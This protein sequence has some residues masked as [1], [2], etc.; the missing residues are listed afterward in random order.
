VAHDSV[1]VFT[2]ESGTVETDPAYVTAPVILANIIP[3]AVDRFVISSV[4]SEVRRGPTSLKK[5]FPSS[6]KAAVRAPLNA[7]DIEVRDELIPGLTTPAPDPPPMGGFIINC[8][9]V[10][11]WVPTESTRACAKEVPFDPTHPI[12]VW[13]EAAAPAALVN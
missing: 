3:Y 8:P 6:I 5:K 10:A 9:I 1:P 12:E 4:I 11:V 13:K 7:L 2:E